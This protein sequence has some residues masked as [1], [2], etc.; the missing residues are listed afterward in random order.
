MIG[1]T[2]IT[3]H[4][5][6]SSLPYGQRD[7]HRLYPIP[8]S[9]PFPRIRRDPSC[10]KEDREELSRLLCYD[11]HRC[12]YS[13]TLAAAC[14]S[15][16][17]VPED[18]TRTPKT[19]LREEITDRTKALDALSYDALDP[20]MYSGTL[21]IR[22]RSDDAI[23]QKVSAPCEHTST[24]APVNWNFYTAFVVLLCRYP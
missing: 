7:D 9:I 22:R 2:E 4:L 15:L 14:D 13:R 1:D 23:A 18:G 5:V 16:P 17:E 21:A 10:N 24:I 11:L 19:A 20:L 3:P 12:G 6:A 8:S